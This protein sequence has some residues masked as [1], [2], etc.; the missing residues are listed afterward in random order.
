M[1]AEQQRGFGLQFKK[2]KKELYLTL[3]EVTAVKQEVKQK[4]EQN[5]SLYLLAYYQM[6]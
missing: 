3:K 5:N 1:L 2:M 4:L 6:R